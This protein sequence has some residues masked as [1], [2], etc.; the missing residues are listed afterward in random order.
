MRM[1]I[2]NLSN[3]IGLLSIVLYIILYFNLQIKLNFL[4]N[5]GQNIYNY[6]HEPVML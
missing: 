3:K 6:F 1:C 4:T 5:V 2:L